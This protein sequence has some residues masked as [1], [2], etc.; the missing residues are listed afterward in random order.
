MLSRF[1]SRLWVQQIF[2]LL[3]VGAEPNS[4]RRKSEATLTT[5]LT[6]GQRR[7]DGVD[8]AAGLLSLR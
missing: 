8:Y 6:L 7:M 1:P 3:P 4:P 5:W 2:R